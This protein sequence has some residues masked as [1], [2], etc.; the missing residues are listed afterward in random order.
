M[1]SL[2]YELKSS[3]VNFIIYWKKEDAEQEVKII[4]PELYFEKIQTPLAIGFTL[5]E[6]IV[7]VENIE[8]CYFIQQS[9]QAW[10]LYEKNEYNIAITVILPI[11]DTIK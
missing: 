9:R 10:R 7:F 6:A 5:E 1:N 3:S 11:F 8:Y 4:L 2:G